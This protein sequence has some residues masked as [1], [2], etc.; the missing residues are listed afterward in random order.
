MLEAQAHRNLM[1]LTAQAAVSASQ[2]AVDKL[3]RIAV[4][5]GPAANGQAPARK[6]GANVL[7]LT[8]WRARV[9]YRAHM[10]TFIYIHALY[11]ELFAVLQAWDGRL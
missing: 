10:Y 1:A 5:P 11:S 6:L 9:L 2:D 8:Q 4:E 7:S 3:G